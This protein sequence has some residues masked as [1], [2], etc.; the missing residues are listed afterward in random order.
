MKQSI[1]SYP[2]LASL[3]SLATLPGCGGN[4]PVDDFLQRGKALATGIDPGISVAFSR[5]RGS[6]EALQTRG[7]V[8]EANYMLA[9]E[10]LLG[11]DPSLCVALRAPNLQI[12]AVESVAKTIEAL[13]LRGS[14][15]EMPGG[16]GHENGFTV[17]AVDAQGV[18][19]SLMIL[20]HS[21]LSSLPETVEVLGHELTHLKQTMDLGAAQCAALP[22]RDRERYAYSTHLQRLEAILQTWAHRHGDQHP[23]TSG[24]RERITNHRA[25]LDHVEKAR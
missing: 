4:A 8:F 18:S 19:R 2:L 21:V 6:P 17:T 9:L 20:G 13:Q 15:H 5:N 24:L 25:Q 1:R 7:R 14:G 3:F 10:D 11:H 12:L 23:L 22:S 16:I